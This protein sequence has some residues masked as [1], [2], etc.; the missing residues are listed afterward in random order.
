MQILA[1]LQRTFNKQT[2]PTVGQL[3]LTLSL[4]VCTQV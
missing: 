1:T 2:H 3:A 4:E